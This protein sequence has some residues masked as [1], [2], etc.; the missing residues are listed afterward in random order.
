MSNQPHAFPYIDTF[1]K[2]GSLTSATGKPGMSLLDYFAAASI[3]AVN[4]LSSM[5]ADAI[6]RQAF[7]IAE[8]M[9]AESRK[10]EGANA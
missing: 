5:N 9:V 3:S 10:R 7:D 6:A 2:I 4:V 1:E 8:A